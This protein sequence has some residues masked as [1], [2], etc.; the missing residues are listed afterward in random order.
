MMSR[1]GILSNFES[2]ITL[3]SLTSSINIMLII[4]L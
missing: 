1:F 4:G 2:Q 3:P